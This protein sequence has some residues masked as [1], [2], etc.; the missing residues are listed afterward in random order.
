M[1]HN[2]HLDQFMQAFPHEGLTFDDVSLCAEYADFLPADTSLATQ[3]TRRIGLSIPML[4]S[5]MDTVTESRMAIAM[6]MLGGIGIVHKNLSVQKQAAVVR[7]VKH[8]LN[9]LIEQPVTFQRRTN[10]AP[11]CQRIRQEK[12]YTFSGF[13]IVDHDHHLV[14]ILTASDIKFT[15]DLNLRIADVMTTRTSSRRPPGTTLEQAYDVMVK[16]KIGKL[17]LVEK[18]KLV[19][20]YSFADVSTLIHNIEPHLQPRCPV[21]TARGGGGG[22]ERP[23]AHGGAG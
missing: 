20:L 18:G 21:P 22:T 3:L 2:P 6:A 12:S 16:N 11:T 14:G 5:A 8:H 9:G 1:S 13:P 4:S 10:P 7:A 19:G 15:R 23:R 17:P